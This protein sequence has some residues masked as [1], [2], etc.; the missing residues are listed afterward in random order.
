M[1]SC[2]NLIVMLSEH[3]AFILINKSVLASTIRPTASILLSLWILN[4]ISLPHTGC[5]SWNMKYTETYVLAN[6]MSMSTYLQALQLDASYILEASD[7][8]MPVQI[9]CL[10]PKICTSQSSQRENQMVRFLQLSFNWTSHSKKL[11][12]VANNDWCLFRWYLRF[13]IWQFPKTAFS[14]TTHCYK[15]PVHL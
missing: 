11:A 2:S 9:F 6:T 12:A 14:S 4:P 7:L 3:W 13:L 10:M 1:H 8:Q 5:M 15:W